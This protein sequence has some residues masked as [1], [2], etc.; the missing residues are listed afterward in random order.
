[1]P[2]NTFLGY[3]EPGGRHPPAASGPGAAGP[4]A[5]FVGACRMARMV[6]T[7]LTVKSSTERTGRAGGSLSIRRDWSLQ[8]RMTNPV[9][10]LVRS[11]MTGAGRWSRLG[12]MYAAHR[13]MLVL[14]VM[15][16]PASVMNRGWLMS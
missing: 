1:M 8:A 12:R 7:R 6:S 2:R 5:T 10:W 15:A 14:I 3:F 16:S 9:T 11:A 4:D 13:A